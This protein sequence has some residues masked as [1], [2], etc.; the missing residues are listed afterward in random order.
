MPVKGVVLGSV[1]MRQGIIGLRTEAF[2]LA[3]TLSR[4]AG[5]TGVSLEALEAATTL[6]SVAN[7]L[8]D[9]ES[10][11]GSAEAQDVKGRLSVV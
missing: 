11:L 2:R 9:V 8:G 1:E 4:D 6:Q 10:Y 5:R 7:M 3:E